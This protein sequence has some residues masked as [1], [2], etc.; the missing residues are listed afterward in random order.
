MATWIQRSVTISP[1]KFAAG[2]RVPGVLG[3]TS[4]CTSRRLEIAK[5]NALSSPSAL[6]SM[7]LTS[8]R[9]PSRSMMFIHALFAAVQ[10]AGIFRKA[11][12]V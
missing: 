7:P 9:R 6:A 3:V 11:S 2:E 8:P 5:I 1:E 10:L 12:T 4:H